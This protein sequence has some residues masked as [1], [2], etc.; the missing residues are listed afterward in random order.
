VNNS[1]KGMV[2]GLDSVFPKGAEAKAA[3]ET[4]KGK[5]APFTT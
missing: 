1:E 4:Q 5:N 3:K 2:Y